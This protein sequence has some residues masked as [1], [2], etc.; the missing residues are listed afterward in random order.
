V[1]ERQLLNLVKQLDWIDVKAM[2]PPKAQETLLDVVFHTVQGSIRFTGKDHILKDEGEAFS[3]A[4][5]EHITEGWWVEDEARHTAWTPLNLKNQ[6]QSESLS[7][8]MEGPRQVLLYSDPLLKERSFPKEALLDDCSAIA[9]VKAVDGGAKTLVLKASNNSPCAVEIGTTAGACD[10]L[11]KGLEPIA[12][13][14]LK[15]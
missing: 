10:L 14:E 12:P 2:V 4:I 5:Y 11:L 3:L 6:W 7:C 8:L 13:S 1:D 15:N 9:F